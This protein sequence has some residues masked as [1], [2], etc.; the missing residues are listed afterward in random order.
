MAKKVNGVVHNMY[1]NATDSGGYAIPPLA[2]NLAL[3]QLVVN[4][5]ESDPCVLFKTSAGKIVKIVSEEVITKALTDILG[6]SAADLDTLREL[7]AQFEGSANDILPMLVAL[8]DRVTAAETAL[9]N[10]ANSSTVNAHINNREN[11]HGVTKAQVGL[12]NLRN[13]EQL[14]ITETAADSNKLGGVAAS[15]FVFTR[16]SNG[17]DV[18]GFIKLFSF[19]KTSG[20]VNWVSD[21]IVTIDTNV[22]SVN[23]RSVLLSV[24][25]RDS[26]I[27]ITP[28]LLKDCVSRSSQFSYSIDGDE[29]SVY[30]NHYA[31]QYTMLAQLTKSSD[32][33]I[34]CTYTK[35]NGVNPIIVNNIVGYNSS[36]SN[37]S[38]V[39]WTANNLYVHGGKAWAAM[40][41]TSGNTNQ[42]LFGYTSGALGNIGAFVRVGENVL[43]FRPQNSTE[44]DI[45]NAGNSNLLSVDWTAKDI[46]LKGSVYKV[47]DSDSWMYHVKRS[48]NTAV[49]GISSDGFNLQFVTNN[50]NRLTILSGGNAGFGT[51][52][53]TDRVHAVGNVRAT[54]KGIFGGNVESN[55]SGIF[56]GDIIAKKSGAVVFAANDQSGGSATRLNDLQDVKLPANLSAKMIMAYDPAQINS[57]GTTG[58][59]TF[60]PAVG[61]GTGKVVADDIESLPDITL[62]G[63]PYAA[64][65]DKRLKENIRPLTGATNILLNFAAKEYEWSE[66]GKKLGLTDPRAYGLIAQEA[67][68]LKDI[69]DIVRPLGI[70][71]YLGIDYIKI[72]PILIA[73]FQEQ[74]KEIV[75]LN[76]L[77]QS[78]KTR[79]NK[80]FGTEAANAKKIETLESEV[81]E[82]KRL[83]NN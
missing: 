42:A 9:G 54:E 67:A 62:E 32:C 11:P 36:N 27:N 31:Y 30:V 71:D 15:Q 69:V 28:T 66:E 37:K 18:E 34:H 77:L 25:S 16:R 74:H 10:K 6:N 7:I 17:G 56:A 51:N 73:G 26:V 60:M 61:V 64:V 83:M 79:A 81:R 39:D 5:S 19:K 1:N 24:D 53:P 21:F 78:I 75:D 35:T 44:Y 49:R 33:V 57:D 4:T 63:S 55:G 72:V 3:G 43:K 40:V 38:D 13:V 41:T 29:V 8:T 68:E 23:S 80:A 76:R 14:G 65:S 58:G 50:A 2:T 59:Y 70:S 47:S 20:G 12:S 46:Y 82:L 52:N 22:S 48:D 45:W